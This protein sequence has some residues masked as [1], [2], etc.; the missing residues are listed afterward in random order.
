MSPIDLFSLPGRYKPWQPR[1]A[2]IILNDVWSRD[3]QTPH[4]HEVHLAA[5]IDWLCRAQDVRDGQADA[6]GVSAGWS[7]EDGWLPSYPETTGYI[8][9]TFLAAADILKRPEL[10]DRAQRMIDWE[11]SLQSPDGAFPGHYGEPG[12]HPVIFN[13]GQILHGMIAG[14]TQLGRQDCLEA[15]LRGARWM[16]AQMDPD[17]CFRRFEHN[18]VP[19][20]YNTR[21]T[22]ALLRVG[23]LTGEQ[24]L[25]AAARRNLDWALTQ[26]S[27]SGWYATN[28]F[29]PGRSPFT[30]T[31]A[32]AIRG[33]LECGA[34]LSE[35]RYLDSALKAGRALAQVQRADG[36]LAG[37]YRD[38]WVADANYACL[39]GIAQMSLNWTRLAQITGDASWRDAARRALDYL[40]RTQ[41]LN[42]PDEA[43]RGGIKGSS[44]IWGDY[45]RF[46]YPNWAAKFFADA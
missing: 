1:H 46:E 29:V 19:H 2:R 17:G 38:R 10:I 21:A 11:L 43:V 7:F 33:F 39:T 13:Q 27:E 8:I 22:W 34:L 25:V 20:V 37:T 18:G 42:D 28:A 35:Q 30:H 23:L 14:Y 15:M 40:K 9:E 5:A 4:P 36:W 44:P 41:R 3:R 12:S 31:I 16:A 32:Y 24:G 26:Q 6:G 45:S